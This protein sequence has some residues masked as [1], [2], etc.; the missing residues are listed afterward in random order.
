MQ[1]N[2]RLSAGLALATGAPRLT[3]ALADGATVADLLAHL[4]LQY[5]GLNSKLPLVL[6]FM[7][8]R[9]VTHAEVLVPDQEIALLMPASG[10][11]H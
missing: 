2:V 1:V 11:I 6:P 5:P 3:L 4:R 10:G 8:G 7:A 9:H